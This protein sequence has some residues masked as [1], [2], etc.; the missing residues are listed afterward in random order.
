[1]E[2]Y[3]SLVY[4]QRS[5]KHVKLLAEVNNCIRTNLMNMLRAAEGIALWFSWLLALTCCS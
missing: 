2:K 1:M 5:T 4:R 3:V